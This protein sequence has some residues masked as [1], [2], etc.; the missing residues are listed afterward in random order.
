[1]GGA[2]SGVKDVAGNALTADLTWTFTVFADT[3]PPTVTATTPANGATGVAATISPTGTFSEAMTASTINGTTVTLTDQA[4]ASA[5]AGTVSYNATSRVVTFDPTSDLGA[6]KVYVA[7]IKGGAASGVKDVAGNAL[8]ADATWTFTV[9][10]PPIDTTPPTV[11]G[12]TPANGATG[13]AATISPTGTFSEAMNASTISGSTVTLTDQG[14]AVAG[15][16]SYNATS[17]VVTFDPTTD[18]GPGKV[19]VATIKGGAAAGVKDVAGNAL[20]ADVTWTFTVASG[21]GSVTFAAPASLA[22]GPH[23]HRG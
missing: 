19:Y 2:A 5:V 4:T 13:V 20:A 3:T 11:T 1:K 14:A 6:G 9:F 18:L 15:T 21:G 22:A 23:T 17:R 8:A 10:A 12:T 7:T 16:V